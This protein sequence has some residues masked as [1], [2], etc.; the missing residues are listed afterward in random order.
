MPGIQLNNRK[1]EAEKK[2]AVTTKTS[3]LNV[4]AIMEQAANIVEIRSVHNPSQRMTMSHHDGM[5]VIDR[6]TSFYFSLFLTDNIA[7]IFLPLF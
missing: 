3:A 2:A 7:S 6:F 1:K 5:I 4:M